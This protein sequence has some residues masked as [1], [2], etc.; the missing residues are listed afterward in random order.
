M[1]ETTR[2]SG[3]HSFKTH[4]TCFYYTN[5]LITREAHSLPQ[6]AK[7]DANVRHQHTY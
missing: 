4:Y 1:N 3:Q 5:R 2:V 7:P 6:L